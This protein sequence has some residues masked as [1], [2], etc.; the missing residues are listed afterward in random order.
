[1]IFRC[2]VVKADASERLGG[3]SQRHQVRDGRKRGEPK[4]GTER[5]DGDGK[6]AEQVEERREARGS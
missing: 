5:E 1:M 2:N 6:P 4:G 3:M